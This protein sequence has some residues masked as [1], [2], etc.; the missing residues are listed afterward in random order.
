LNRFDSLML[1]A[2]G[3]LTQLGYYGSAYRLPSLFER[4]PILAMATLFPIMSQLAVRDPM[5]LRRLY[6]RTLLGLVLLVVPMV[7]GVIWL[8]PFIVR[9]WLGAEF[10]PVVPLLRVVILSTALVYLGISAGNLLVALSNPKAN[11]YAMAAA[12][13]VN[14]ALNFLWIPRHGALGAAWATV[15]GFG[16]LSVGA[17][18]L[19][20]M[21][22]RRAIAQHPRGTSA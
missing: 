13:T 5:A 11:F 3:G 17:L 15:V 10:A 2:L 4:L 8:A 12:T 21:A 22:L 6:R 14:V 18:V 20:E 19:A 7:A 1:Q 9:V 16:V